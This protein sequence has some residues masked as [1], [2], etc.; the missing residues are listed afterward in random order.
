M[1]RT[2]TPQ[3]IWPDL[4]IFNGREPHTVKPIILADG[5][6]LYVTE[7][8]DPVVAAKLSLMVQ[9]QIASEAK[10]NPKRVATEYKTWAEVDKAMDAEWRE[11]KE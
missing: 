2:L 1:K 7:H 5:T 4:T 10:R 3:P 11:T 8:Y 9:E 6:G